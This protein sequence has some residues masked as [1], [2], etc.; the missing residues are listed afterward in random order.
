MDLTCISRPHCNNQMQLKGV[1][2]AE[3]E[4]RTSRLSPLDQSDKRS[5]RDSELTIL[6]E[7]TP[8]S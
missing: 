1:L 7:A 8:T 5:E 2:K 6:G 3:N 4:A